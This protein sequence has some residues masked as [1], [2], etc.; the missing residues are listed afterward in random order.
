MN[1]TSNSAIILTVI[2]ILIIGTF[3]VSTTINRLNMESKE[4]FVVGTSTPFPPF[5][6][7]VGDQIVG[8]DIDLAKKIADRLDRTL[9][10]KDF[11]DF[12]ALLPSLNAGTLDMVAAAITITPER[13]EIVNFSNSYYTSSQAVLISS[14]NSIITPFTCTVG[15]QNYNTTISEFRDTILSRNYII[16]YQEETTSQYWI[17]TN[18]PNVSTEAFNNLQIGIGYLNMNAIDIIIIDEP[19]AKSYITSS[20]EIRGT[21]NTNEE[22]AFVVQHND[23]QSLLPEINALLEELNEDNE[24]NKLITKWFGGN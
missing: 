11:S 20:L 12:D 7:R 6:S 21:I 15:D 4:K 1:I 3:T 23:P 13:E 16:G 14:S 8:F 2:G 24:Y 17:E 10:I 19:V 18:L 5:E 22:Y 9:V